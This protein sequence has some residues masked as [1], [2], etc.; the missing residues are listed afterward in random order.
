MIMHSNNFFRFIDEYM[1][2]C[3]E[4]IFYKTVYRYVEHEKCWIGGG[5]LEGPHLSSGY[6]Y[7]E[8]IYTPLGKWFAEKPAIIEVLKWPYYLITWNVWLFVV[9][10]LFALISLFERRKP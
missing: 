3:P 7:D 5:F 2:P 1:L 9:S 4:R 6:V 10:P 8:K